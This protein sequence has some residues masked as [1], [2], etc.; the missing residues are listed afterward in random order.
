MSEILDKYPFL[1]DYGVYTYAEAGND[2]VDDVPPGWRPVFFE[3]CEEI[4]T[5]LEN[6][7]INPKLLVFDQVKEKF[8]ELRIYHHF[9][10]D[11]EDGGQDVP[12]FVKE[13]V[14]D[15]ID[16]CC[17]KTKDICFKCGKAA[18][19]LSTGWI[20]PHCTKCATEWNDNANQRYGKDEPLEKNFR[21]MCHEIPS[22]TERLQ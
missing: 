22:Q 11:E 19:W 18:N 6:E 20:L 5:F 9:N 15:I 16:S 14:S 8:G 12:S 7:N 4:K 1:E 3:M 10:E 21:R 2:F 17:S 13:S